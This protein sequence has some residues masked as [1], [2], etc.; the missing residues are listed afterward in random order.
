[1]QRCSICRFVPPTKQGRRICPPDVASFYPNPV[2]GQDWCYTARASERWSFVTLTD[3][4]HSAESYAR[5]LA[6]LG[7]R[8][9]RLADALGDRPSFF[10]CPFF[11][12]SGNLLL[13]EPE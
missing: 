6:G 8:Q 4:D 7:L 13:N 9:A 3:L 12:V 1:M 2:I 11:V 5:A 10:V